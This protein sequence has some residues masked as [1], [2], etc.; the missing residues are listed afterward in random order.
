MTT[1]HMKALSR[2]GDVTIVEHAGKKTSVSL[3]PFS[4][5]VVVLQGWTTKEQLLKELCQMCRD[6]PDHTK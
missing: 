3:Q 5:A 6:Y 2:K 4:G 1:D